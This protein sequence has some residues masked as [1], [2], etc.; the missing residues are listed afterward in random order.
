MVTYTSWLMLSQ[1]TQQVS[2][3]VCGLLL[4]MMTLSCFQHCMGWRWRWRFARITLSWLT[5]QV[6]P[7]V[8]HRVC[9]WT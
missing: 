5:I 9:I 1:S 7:E 2:G 6:V 4:L 8:Q 3:R